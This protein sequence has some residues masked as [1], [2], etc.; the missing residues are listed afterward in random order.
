MIRRG[1]TRATIGAM[2]QPRRTPSPASRPAT[3]PAPAP[4]TPGRP[5]ALDEERLAAVTD[6]FFS[7]QTGE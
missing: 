7:N 6:G 2:K 4:V 3:T 5:A 1:P